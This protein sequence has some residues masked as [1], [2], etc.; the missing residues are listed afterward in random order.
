MLVSHGSRDPRP[1]VALDRLAYLVDQKLVTREISRVNHRA[2]SSPRN[3][4]EGTTTLLCEPESINV[5][6]ATL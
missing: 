3:L 5:R 6:T 2:V 1:Q 4:T